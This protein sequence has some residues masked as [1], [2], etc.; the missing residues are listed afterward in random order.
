MQALL[1]E[2]DYVSSA[3]LFT[4]RKYA[5]AGHLR[6]YN[7]ETFIHH[8]RE[9]AVLLSRFP[10]NREILAAA[11]LI[12]SVQDD[13]ADRDEIT[14]NFGQKVAD[15]TT[16]LKSFNLP[17]CGRLSTLARVNF[18]D[19]RQAEPVLQTM[20]MADLFVLAHTIS[21]SNPEQLSPFTDWLTLHLSAF[22]AANPVLVDKV[23][24]WLT[25]IAQRQC[26]LEK[27][28]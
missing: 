22:P 5:L 24:N 9:L 2:Y 15:M 3:A 7:G 21:E 10:H 28:S 18:V 11:W 12:R 8:P 23:E 26:S 19:I 13:Y 6:R 27:V 17:D 16:A 14:F 20:A 25:E 4:A 1:V